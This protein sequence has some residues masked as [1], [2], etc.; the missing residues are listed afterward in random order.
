MII[1]W[2]ERK[3]FRVG[4]AHTVTLR[5]DKMTFCDELTQSDRTGLQGR[6]RDHMLTEGIPPVVYPSRTR[7]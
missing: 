4:S 6:M 5:V 2:H 1:S 3:T 7:T